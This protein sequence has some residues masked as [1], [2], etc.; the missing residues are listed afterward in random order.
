M[1]EG[2]R[3]VCPKNGQ[4]TRCSE[5]GTTA[6]HVR[7]EWVQTGKSVPVCELHGLRLEAR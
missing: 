7:E 4:R 6:P 2:M 5:C 1:M 3:Y